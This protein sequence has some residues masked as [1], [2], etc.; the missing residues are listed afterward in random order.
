MIVINRFES[1]LL[2]SNMYVVTEGIHSIVIDPCRD[3]TPGKGLIIDKIL[4][5]HE[6]YDH[7]SGVNTWKEYSGAPV[8]CSGACAE[9]I[10]DPRTNLAR[11]FMD[12]CE[13]QTWIS[14]IDAPEYDPD[15]FCLAD[16]TFSD[17]MS[18]SWMGHEWDLFEIPGHSMGSI[19]I[20]LDKQFFFSGDSLLENSDI[21]LRAPGGSRKKWKE[22][23]ERRIKD[24]PL[25]IKV[26]PGHFSDFIYTKK[27]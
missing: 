6:H 26:F 14:I 10:Q 18:F 4:L 19:G 24:L 8:L 11:Y 15:Y 27:L 5:T 22:T 13:L 17:T 9:R 21:E 2:A 20:L 7:I 23:G 1:D 16:E 12:F 25:G 3:I